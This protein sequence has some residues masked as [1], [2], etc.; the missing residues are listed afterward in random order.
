MVRR[1]KNA[2]QFAANHGYE[3]GYGVARLF[4]ISDAQTDVCSA[5]TTESERKRN[6]PHGHRNEACYGFCSHMIRYL[7]LPILVTLAMLVYGNAIRNS[8]AMDDDLYIFRNA[9]VTSHTVK[10]LF[11]PNKY[12]TVFR[13]VTFATL[14][15][16]YELGSEN[17]R[18]YHVFNLVLHAGVTLLL[19]WVTRTI[20]GQEPRGELVAFVAALLFALHPIHTEAVTSIIGRSELLAAGFLLGAW[21]LHLYDRPYLAALSLVIALLSK[22]SAVAFLPLVLVGDYACGKLKPRLRYI[23]LAGVT[24]LYAV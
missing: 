5:Q 12:T 16:N 24:L 3:T 8:F 14:A 6:L 13:P 9:Q 23:L 10:E 17:P 15:A 21:L 22:E 1:G 18:G 11:Q 4:S 19:F 2:S 7:K 20:L